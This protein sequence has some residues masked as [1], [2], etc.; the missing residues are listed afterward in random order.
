[1]LVHL[2]TF[3]YASAGVATLK[4]GLGAFVSYMLIHGVEDQTYAT[5]EETVDFTEETY[6]LFVHVH[7]FPHN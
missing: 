7:V 6:V 3:N 1:M 5:V 4:L 2:T